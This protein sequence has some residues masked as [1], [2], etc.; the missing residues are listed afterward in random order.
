MI[1]ISKKDGSVESMGIDEFSR[2]M[3]LVEAFHFI[4]SKASELNVDITTMIKPL[5]IEMYIKER[6]SA[7]R[8]DVE[9]EYKLGLL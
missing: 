8:H 4:E 3:C 7:M 6:F 5:A 1:S 2:W 9:C